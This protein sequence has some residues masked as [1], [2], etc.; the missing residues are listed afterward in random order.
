MRCESENN[1]AGKDGR[2]EPSKQRTPRPEALG[3]LVN[4]RDRREPR[5]EHLGKWRA[6]DQGGDQRLGQETATGHS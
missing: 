5:G 2:E 3:R 1:A 6:G 4:V